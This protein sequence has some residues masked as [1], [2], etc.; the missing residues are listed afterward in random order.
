MILAHP[1][2]AAW[3]AATAGSSGLQLQTWRC[4]GTLA[5]QFWVVQ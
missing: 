3:A 1:V 4:N 5:Q 2:R